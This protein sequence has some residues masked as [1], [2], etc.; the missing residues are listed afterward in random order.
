[1]EPRSRSAP[2]TIGSQFNTRIVW[3]HVLHRLRRADK[4]TRWGINLPPA[5]ICPAAAET[6]ASF[7]ANT[8][9]AERSSNRAGRHGEN[10]VNFRP[11]R[12]QV[13]TEMFYHCVNGQ[14]IL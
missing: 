2:N 1:M 14:T 3:R 11:F 7:D 5:A 6:A 9:L 4:G 10:T 13:P 8:A 12:N